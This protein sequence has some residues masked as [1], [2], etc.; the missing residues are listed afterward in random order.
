[1]LGHIVEKKILSISFL[2]H[3][4]DHHGVESERKARERKIS[5]KLHVITPAKKFH[6]LVTFH[7]PLLRLNTLATTSLSFRWSGMKE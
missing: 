2:F 6:D 1:M 5:V 3:R 4:D 7:L